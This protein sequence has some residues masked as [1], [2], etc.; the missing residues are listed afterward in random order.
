MNLTDQ[1]YQNVAVWSQVLGA[2]AFLVVL[3]YIFQK[4][5]APA[6]L[7]AQ[8]SKNAELADAEARR[9]TMKAEIDVAARDLSAADADAAAIRTRAAHQA[10]IDAQKT[11]ADA[12]SDAQRVIRNAEGELD[13]ARLAASDDVRTRLLERALEIARRS[14]A[15]TI[16]AAK[17]RGLVAQV[18]DALGRSAP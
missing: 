18:L 16:D 7:A 15:T 4:F 9:D 6:V 17:N 3:V 1:V 10:G 13:R 8:A 5:I 12:Q 11:L 2:L 14:A